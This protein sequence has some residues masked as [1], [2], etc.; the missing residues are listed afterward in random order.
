[1]KN[2][3]LKNHSFKFLKQAI[4]SKKQSRN[5]ELNTSLLQIKEVSFVIQLANLNTR[6]QKNRF[7]F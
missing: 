3:I 4:L 7:P 2:F 6:F 1:M 5:Y